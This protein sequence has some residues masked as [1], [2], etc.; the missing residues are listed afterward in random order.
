MSLGG[1]VTRNPRKLLAADPPQDRA[2]TDIDQFN[3]RGGE[4]TTRLVWKNLK[5]TRSNLKTNLVPDNESLTV[6]N[7][8]RSINSFYEAGNAI[9]WQT[10]ERQ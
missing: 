2:T 1:I 10:T 8:K 4:N 3:C 7:R 9:I 5:T 6:D